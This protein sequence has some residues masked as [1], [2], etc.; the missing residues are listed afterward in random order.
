M[1]LENDLVECSVLQAH[2]LQ[3]PTVSY[4]PTVLRILDRKMTSVDQLCSI[5][6]PMYAHGVVFSLE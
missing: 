1:L 3:G 4:T 2:P 5:E 6:R